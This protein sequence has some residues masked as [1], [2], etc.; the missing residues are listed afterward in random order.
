MVLPDPTCRRAHDPSGLGAASPVRSRGRWT[1]GFGLAVLAGGLFVVSMAPG[2]FGGETALN[3]AWRAGLGILMFGALVATRGLY[4]DRQTLFI[5]GPWCAM[6]IL[7]TVASGFESETMLLTARTLILMAFVSLQIGASERAGPGRDLLRPFFWTVF[8]GV[9]I[10]TLIGMF[11]VLHGGWTWEAGRL[12]KAQLQLSG[13]LSPN[14]AVFILGLCVFFL[15]AGSRR[16][17]IISLTAVA[18]VGVILATRT[19]I[20]AVFLAWTLVG[21][22]SLTKRLTRPDMQRPTAIAFSTVL[23]LGS[24]GLAVYATQVDSPTIV[25]ALAGRSYLWTA[26]LDLWS[27]SPL[28]GNGPVSVTESV[29]LSYSILSFLTSWEVDSLLSLQGG[30]FHSVWF[31]TLVTFG[32]FGFVVLTWLYLRLVIQALTHSNSGSLALITIYIMVRS[33]LEYSGLFANANS[34]LDFLC[35]LAVCHA[36]LT[37]RR[38]ADT[39][40]A[41]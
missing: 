40:T 34:P 19:P 36:A 33:H 38:N 20:I 14:G 39:G 15:L 37:A 11:N 22:W 32:I 9:I 16:L 28:F 1:P 6:L 3:Y 30:G 24:F 10:L 18:V 2:M 12:A 17:T 35:A 23:V 7:N 41:N 29:A 5:F 13:E 8:V 21:L 4:L 25:R 26:A 27:A 31:Q